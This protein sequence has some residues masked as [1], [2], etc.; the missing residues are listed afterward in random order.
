MFS[1]AVK[2]RKPARARNTS[3]RYRWPFWAKVIL[4]V[5]ASGVIGASATFLWRSVEKGPGPSARVPT[6]STVRGGKAGTSSPASEPSSLS[7]VLG[8]NGG[9]LL[10][11]ALPTSAKPLRVPI[12][13]YHY[14]DATPPPAGPYAAGLTVP[15]AQFAAQMDYLAADGYHPVTLEQIYAAMA[16][17]SHLPPKPVALTFDDGGLD[18]YT[19]AYPILRSHHFVATFFVITGFVGRP[20]CMT[21]SDLQRMQQAGMA[22]ESHTVNH[23]DLRSLAPARMQDELVQSWNTIER[24]LGKAPMALAYP[25]GAYNPAVIAAVR[26]AG[27]RL[28]VTTHPGKTLHPSHAYEWPRLRI[29]PRLDLAGFAKELE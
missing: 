8:S 11:R 4:A 12:L 22:V 14:V 6:A 5:V 16:G 20:I 25:S 18:D 1:G 28:A 19:V 23:L 21:W 7:T 9:P 27:Y 26:A 2:E 17:L 15:T 3:E 13:M 10:P 24:E 29:G